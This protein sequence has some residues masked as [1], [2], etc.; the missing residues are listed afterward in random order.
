LHKNVGICF[1][2]DLNPDY[3]CPSPGEWVSVTFTNAGT[4][5]GGRYKV[6]A[7]GDNR[8]VEPDILRSRDLSSPSTPGLLVEYPVDAIG[9][10][11]VQPSF[12]EIT[13]PL[14]EGT[15]DSPFPPNT[16]FEVLRDW[17]SP[18]ATGQP[19]NG[20][21][22]MVLGPNGG[23]GTPV[24]TI[25][26]ARIKRIRCVDS[27]DRF[28]A[29][30]GVYSFESSLRSDSP[31]G[32]IIT[33]NNYVQ[34]AQLPAEPGV[35]K[36]PGSYRVYPPERGSLG[37]RGHRELSLVAHVEK[38]PEERLLM[39]RDTSPA[40]ESAGSITGYTGRKQFKEM[41]IMENKERAPTCNTSLGIYRG[42]P[43]GRVYYF[44]S[45]LGPGASGTVVEYELL[46]GPLQGETHRV[47]C[48][49]LAAVSPAL[50]SAWQES[51][52][53][54]GANL[55]GLDVPRGTEI[56]LLGCQAVLDA[57]PHL[58]IDF[59]LN[60]LVDNGNDLDPACFMDLN[61]KEDYWCCST[62]R[63]RECSHHCAPQS[64]ADNCYGTAGTSKCR[65]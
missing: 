32:R 43:Y 22:L 39:S 7:P 46:E 15:Y 29:T 31:I 14:L 23:L 54:R 42:L 26:R 5:S 35:R 60:S 41:T 9:G 47:R 1:P 64:A 37:Y 6:V 44:T 21:D 59:G 56:G 17:G 13:T 20:L 45:N 62:P 49:H 10:P 33:R 27:S 4:F 53:L 19:Y 16:S 57:P 51:K 50:L 12:A 28:L 30:G 2:E 25:G 36:L 11:M 3:H 61:G 55:V 63:E 18:T 40:V 48:M 38:T 24:L 34:Y 52:R 65:N 58:H 8:Y